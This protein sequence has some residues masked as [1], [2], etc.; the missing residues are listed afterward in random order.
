M[1][2][3]HFSL[4]IIVTT[5]FAFSQNKTINQTQF[6]VDSLRFFTSDS[7]NLQLIFNKSIVKIVKDSFFLNPLSTKKS[8]ELYDFNS[9][10]YSNVKDYYDTNF[11]VRSDVGEVYSLKKDLLI[12]I[13]FSQKTRAF[14]GANLIFHEK[15]IF[16]FFGY[17]FFEERNSVNQFDFDSK[18]WNKVII[19]KDSYQPEAR[20]NSIHHKKGN[21]VYFLGGTNSNLDQSNIH[22][23][24]MIV[25]DFTD[26]KFSKI[27]TLKNNLT[28]FNTN[29][30]NIVHLDDRKSLFFKEDFI[31]LVDF[32]LLNYRSLSGISGI[33]NFSNKVIVKDTLYYLDIKQEG[34]FEIKNIA[35]SDLLNNFS[36]P[37]D[38]LEKVYI[39]QNSVRNSLV[40][41]LIALFLYICIKLFKLRKIKNSQIL[42]Q[43]QYI[44]FKNIII[45]L[46]PEESKII[47]FLITKPTVQ[48]NQ[49]FELD[50][51]SEY[52]N[53][54]IKIYVP[55]LIDQIKKKIE[56]HSNDSDFKLKIAFEKNKFD[57]RMKEISLK[58]D[59]KIYNGWFFYIFNF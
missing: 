29:P 16:S 32:D 39:T 58:G 36:E 4:L 42:K 23:L 35:L 8:N 37:E 28:F 50:V 15:A 10:N 17:G 56:N 40:L 55:K 13:D 48:L 18:Q 14:S 51:F 26:Q 31:C 53:S 7:N 47:D 59:I 24:D 43:D 46:T 1:R 5:S 54:Y 11:F 25:Y 34:E 38:L 2:L 22:L 52:S 57:K 9:K 6:G 30:N 45:L 27:G 49:V 33:N 20:R 21:Q 41:V 44:T 3:V 19:N 12:R